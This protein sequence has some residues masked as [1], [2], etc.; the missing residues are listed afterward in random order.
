VNETDGIGAYGEAWLEPDAR[1]G[2]A[3]LERAWAP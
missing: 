1:A 2:A 3:L